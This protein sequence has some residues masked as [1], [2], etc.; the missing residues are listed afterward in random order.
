MSG[1]ASGQAAGKAGRRVDRALLATYHEARLAELL[2]RV[3]D[4]FADY[5]AGRIDAFELDGLIHQYTLAARELWKFCAVSGAQAEF[6]AR[7]LE[8]WR[9]RGEEPNW[10]QSPKRRA[11]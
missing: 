6:A 1:I 5:D 4:G 3:R 8:L 2:E 9:Q 7:T 11:R 10:W